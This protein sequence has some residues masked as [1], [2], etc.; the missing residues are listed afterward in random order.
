MATNKIESPKKKQKVESK[1]EKIK[2]WETSF[3]CDVI[4]K[5]KVESKDE[6]IKRL[7][8][9]LQDIG[10]IHKNITSILSNA[11]DELNYDICKLKKDHA[12]E[13]KTLQFLGECRNREKVIKFVKYHHTLIKSIEKLEDIRMCKFLEENC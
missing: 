3:K 4:K 8:I 12:E 5:Q 9:E 13:I 6:K 1:D 2:R 10:Y 7:E 11:I